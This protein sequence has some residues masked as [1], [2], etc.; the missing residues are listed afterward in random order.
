MRLS[1]DE[2]CKQF[3]M[4]KEMLSSKIRA[5][6]IDYIV[7]N[8]TVYIIVTPPMATKQEI[9]NTPLEQKNIQKQSV[10]PQKSKITVATLLS[11]YQKENS[12]LKNKI[13]FLEAKIDKLIDDKEQLLRQEKD[14]IEEIYTTK[15]EQLKNIL[16]LVHKNIKLQKEQ[17][18]AQKVENFSYKNEAEVL[19][20]SEMVELKEYLKSLNLRSAQRKTIK[21]RFLDIYD[22]DI[23]IIQQNGRLYLNLLKYDYSDLLAC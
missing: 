1:V 11:L 4:S 13:E 14:K 5:K 15:D 21:K 3:K 8:D 23:R 19:E 22:S 9:I 17:L 6:K 12:F 2:Y 16:E 7:E 20:D 18:E 10:L